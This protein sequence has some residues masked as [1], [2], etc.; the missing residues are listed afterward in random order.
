[1]NSLKI[2][3]ALFTGIVIFCFATS[4]DKKTIRN[5]QKALNEN[6]SYIPAGKLV[7]EKDT[8]SIN[9]FLMFKTEI[10]NFEY[11][12]FLND[13]LAKGE[14]E[15]YEIAKIDSTIWSKNSKNVKY[16]EYYHNHPAYRDFPVLNITKE[17]AELYCEWVSNKINAVLGSNLKFRL[18]THEEWMYAAHGNLEISPYPWGGPY[19]RN[20]RGVYL[21]NFLSFDAGT[22][23]K[24]SSGNYNVMPNAYFGSPLGNNYADIT[25][26]VKSYYP[27][28]YDLYN[29][30]GNVA[31]MISNKALV[32]GGSWSD[33]GYD[34]R[35]ESTRNYKGAD[36]NVGFRI[37]ATISA[38][39]YD[40]LKIPKYK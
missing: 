23:T 33:P 22:I 6:Y 26:P 35:I 16:E 31:E 32:V 29:M 11:R 12:L 5:V 1:M 27:N 3:L 14:T 19:L 15:K 4:A 9:S 21:A 38:K 7:F 18:P 36:K 24:D 10:S 28:Y 25:A 17:G 34:V 40:W 20:S 2:T 8:L 30:S 13:L 37:V 39:E